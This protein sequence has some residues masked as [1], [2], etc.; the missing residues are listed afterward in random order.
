MDF[1][2]GFDCSRDPVD[3]NI[4][5]LVPLYGVGIDSDFE[6][7]FFIRVQY[8]A[9]LVPSLVGQER[10]AVNRSYATDRGFGV[11]PGSDNGQ[12]GVSI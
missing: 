5:A 6:S 7:R 10:R 12:F 3:V 8:R 2:A 4:R 11:P 1:P 9:R